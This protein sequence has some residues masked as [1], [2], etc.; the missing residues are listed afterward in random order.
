MVI[1]LKNAADAKADL[2]AAF[3]QLQTYKREI[4]S[5]FTYNALLV[6]SDG[7]SARAG[8]LSAS[9]SRFSQW[10]H[11]L[12]SGEIDNESNT[13]ELKILTQ[14]MFNQVTLLDLIRH[15]SVFEKIKTVDPTTEVVT[16]QTIK[17]LAAYHQYYAVNKAVESV[18]AATETNHRGGVVW[19]TQGSGKSSQWCS[20]AA[21]LF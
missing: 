16:L 20:S 6:I 1:E 10:K 21:N 9:Y 11:K 8:S 15:F 5:L 2:Q 17:K 19:H 13:N 12:P 7:I 14:G 4:P 18:I 3:N